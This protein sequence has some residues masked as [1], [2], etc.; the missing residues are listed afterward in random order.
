LL[1]SEWRSLT[2]GRKSRKW[3]SVRVG[4]VPGHQVVRAVQSP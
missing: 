4:R 1:H 3:R 2:N